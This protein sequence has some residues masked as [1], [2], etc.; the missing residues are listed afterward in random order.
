MRR[1]K[2][3]FL[4]VGNHPCLDFVNTQMIVRGKL[5]DLL[6]SFEDVLLWLVHTK[7]LT[8]SQADI[9]RTE[10]DQNETVSLLQQAK[11]LRSTLRDVAERIASRKPIPDSTIDTINKFM[12]PRLGYPELVRTKAGFAR[13][14]HTVTALKDGLLTPLAVAAV[15][16]L[17]LADFALIKKCAN[18]ACILYFYDTTRNHGR[19]WCSMELCGNRMKVAAFFQRKRTRKK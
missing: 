2:P 3:P 4:F 10:L 14:F 8:R 11:T 5:T 16:L 17:C 15:D 13:S 19:N 9:A 12:S 18:A 1:E 7:L 6:E